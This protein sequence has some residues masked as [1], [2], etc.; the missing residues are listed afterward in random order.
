VLL[1]PGVTGIAVITAAH[2]LARRGVSLLRATRAIETMIAEGKVILSL[3]AVEDRTALVGELLAAGVYA[4]VRTLPDDLRSGIVKARLPALRARLGMTQEQF[5]LQ[6]GFELKTLR[7]WE[8]GRKVDKAVLSYL[9]VIDCDP[10]TVAR[11]AD[12]A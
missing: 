9:R 2:V 5:A 3:P 11:I 12:L 7:G 8:Q 6:F 4:K 1:Q 10:E